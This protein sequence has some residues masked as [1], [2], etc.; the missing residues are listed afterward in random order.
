MLLILNVGTIIDINEIIN[1]VD[2]ILLAYHGGFYGAIAIYEAITGLTS[3]TG[4]LPFTILKDIKKDIIFETFKETKTVYKEDIYVGYRYHH[5]F[6][7]SNILYPLGYSEN[8]SNFEIKD[9]KVKVNQEKIEVTFKMKNIGTFKS[10]KT[11]FFYLEQPHK[12]LDK[13]KYV[14]AHFYKPDLLEPNEEINVTTKFNLYNVAA[15]DDDGSVVKNGI[16]LEKG[17]YKL[18]LDFILK[19]NFIVMIFPLMSIFILAILSQ[20]HWMI[21]F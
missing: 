5:T 19:I 12:Y 9:I 20:S 8:Y 7:E 10:N 6:L 4:S 3:P 11:I 14:I 16:L 18:H 21:L 17:L 2:A 13:P 15:Y 1:D